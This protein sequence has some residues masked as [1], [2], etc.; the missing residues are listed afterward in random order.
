MASDVQTRLLDAAEAVVYRRGFQA[1]STEEILQEAGAAR[2]SLY[3]LFGSKEKLVLAALERRN[4]RWL[5]W[6]EETANA[7][8]ADGRT[9]LLG[10]FDTLAAWFAE[11]GFNGCAFTNTAATDLP[12]DHPLRALALAHKRR[13]AGFVRELCEQAGSPDAE[14]A[15]HQIALL[16]EGAIDTAMVDPARGATAA[17]DGRALAAT[18]IASWIQDRTPAAEAGTT[19][20]IMAMKQAEDRAAR[21]GFLRALGLGAGAA[22]VATTAEAQRADR[23]PADQA[24]KENQSQRLA[25]R[26]QPNAADVQAFYR[27]N[28]YYSER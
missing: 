19:G 12:P 20:R 8:G 13:L 5:A 18:L 9:R 17:A 14:A 21:R 22:A 26:Y 1:A 11:P 6:F 23:V 16:V 28:R 7:T 15:S 10:V 25:A 2:M 27:T 3:R 24:R 4:G